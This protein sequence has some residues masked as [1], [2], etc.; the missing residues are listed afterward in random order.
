MK[1]KL[2][3]FFAMF[4]IASFSFGQQKSACDNWNWLIGNWAGEGSGQPGQGGGKFSFSINL[5]SNIIVRKS[6]SE[7]PATETKPAIKH[8][9]LMV[10]YKDTTGNLSNAIYFDNEGHVI[11]Y[12]ITYAAKSIVLTSENVP[13]TPVFRLTYSL[14]DNEIVDTKFEMSE[15]GKKYVT[16]IQGKSKKAK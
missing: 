9:D 1:M 7:Y 14:L 13:G 4:A 8:D 10:I 16:Y 5:D 2:V 15:D 6:H 12:S 11:N 3:L